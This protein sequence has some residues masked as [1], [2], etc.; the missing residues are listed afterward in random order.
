MPWI[1]MLGRLSGAAGVGPASGRPHSHAG[2]HRQVGLPE[3]RGPDSGQPRLDDGGGGA[4]HTP[5]LRAGRFG[6][7]P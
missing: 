6:A 5:G 2:L 7:G 4:A 3:G 1:A